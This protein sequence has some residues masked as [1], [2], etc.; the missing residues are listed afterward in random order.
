M[1]FAEQIKSALQRGFKTILSKCLCFVYF[2][3]FYL[4]CGSVLLLP[5]PFNYFLALHI[6]VLSSVKV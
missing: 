1:S 3:L 6:P 2:V 4:F 5:S